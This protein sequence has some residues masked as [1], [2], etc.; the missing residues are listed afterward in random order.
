MIEEIIQKSKQRTKRVG[1]YAHKFPDGDAISS[2]CALVQYLKSQGVEAR[3]IVTTPIRTFKNIVGDIP[4]TTEVGEDEIA[5]ILDTARLDYAQNTLFQKSLVENIYS[6]DHHEKTQE[7][8]NIEEELGIPSQNVIRNS[9]A[10]SVCEILANELPEEQITLP[11]AE[12]LTVGILTDTAR[13]KFP[14]TNTL[15]VL[16]KLIQM[17][18]D[19][20]KVLE[21]CT[22][23]SSLRSEIGLAKLLL[24]SER[25]LIGDTL[26]IIL[27][28]E[29][30]EVRWINREYG[31]RSP[32]KRIFKMTD[33]KNCS[34]SCILAE[35]EPNQYDVE[36]RSVEAWGN[37]NVL[38]IAN[39]HQGGGHYNASGCTIKEGGTREEIT[40][41][42]KQQARELYQQQGANVQEITPNEQ[43]MELAN[44]LEKTQRL[45]RK[46][47][48]EILRQ[49]SGLIKAGANYDYM[50]RK[51]RSFGQFML[52]NE[53][54]SRIPVSV[55][56]QANP[57][58]HIRLLE[59]DI[60]RLSKKYQVSQEDILGIINIFSN[61]QV[62]NA[63]IWLPNGKSSHIDRFGNINF[64]N[65]NLGRE[66]SGE[67]T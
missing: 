55:Y 14:K 52:G 13:L 20:E 34:F 50:Y 37:F 4:V 29:N 51:T 9:K 42:I 33:I 67:R 30:R 54:L 47:T 1:I 40:T 22:T 26:G 58:V 36:F 41:R 62:N 60:S 16:V 61:I 27:P 19:Y 56:S 6:I 7:V 18:V 39:L 65:G 25:F 32:Q 44:I 8:M 31:V 11:I 35:N 53:L 46:V 23:K 48:P 57:V 10:G 45:T 49:V 28:I 5:I 15:E 12:L 3:Y 66:I 59:Q 24:K 21:K 17:G 63:T 64:G 43:D 2:S 38:Q